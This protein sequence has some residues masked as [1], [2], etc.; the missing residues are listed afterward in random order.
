M[1]S[2]LGVFPHISLSED[3]MEIREKM[4]S[5]GVVSQID[6][7]YPLLGHDLILWCAVCLKP[8][9]G[10]D[11]SVQYCYHRWVI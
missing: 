10:E 4:E 8:L 7:A 5:Y 11:C 6:A 3:P 2:W 9:L 1:D